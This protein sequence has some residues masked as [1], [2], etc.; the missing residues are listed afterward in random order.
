M[1]RAGRR[2]RRLLLGSLLVSSLLVAAEPEDRDSP[3]DASAVSN[4]NAATPIRTWTLNLEDPQEPSRWRRGPEEINP[5][6]LRWSI[7]RGDLGSGQIGPMLLFE[8]TSGLGPSSSSRLVRPFGS[9][10]QPDPRSS[11]A[12]EWVWNVEDTRLSDAVSIGLASDG[13]T[14]ATQPLWSLAFSHSRYTFAWRV[15]FDPEDRWKRHRLTLRQPIWGSLAQGVERVTGLVVSFQDPVRQRLRLASVRVEEWPPDS[16]PNDPLLK[17]HRPQLD[18][19][20]FREQAL[21]SLIGARAGALEDLDGDGLPELLAIQYRDYAHLYRNDGVR[22]L[23]RDITAPATLALASIGTGAMFFDPDLDGDLDLVSTAEFDAPRLFLNSGDLRFTPVPNLSLEPPSFWYGCAADDADL[24]G[25][26]DLAC[27]TALDEPGVAVI[28]NRGADGWSAS[29]PEAIRQRPSIARTGFAVAWADLCSA[30]PGQRTPPALAF[31]HAG[32]LAGPVTTTAKAE[33][34]VRQPLGFA[35]EGFVFEDL[36]RDGTLDLA[37]LRE[38]K[39][40]VGSALLFYRG[41]GAGEL[42]RD[43]LWSSGAAARSAEVLLAEDFDND[44]DLDLYLCQNRANS[45]LLL[46][47]GKGAYRDVASDSGLS[48]SGDCDA[49]IAGDIDGDGRVDIVVLAYGR[50]PELL[51]NQLPTQNWIG[52]VVA[53][54][55]GGEPIGARVDMLDPASGDTLATRWT[56]RGRG[57]GSTGPWELRFGLGA[58]EHVD[59]RVRF[60]N[61][62]ERILHGVDAGATH[63]VV[64]PGTGRIGPLRATL[65]ERKAETSRWARRQLVQHSEAALILPTVAVLLGLVGYSRGRS[66][67]IGLALIALGFVGAFTVGSM[68]GRGF[69]GSLPMLWLSGSTVGLALKPLRNLTL[70]AVRQFSR[71]RRTVVSIEQV[72]SLTTD[73]RHSG[74][75]SRALI[76]IQSRLQNL[77]VEGQLHGM[78]LEELRTLAI[79]FRKSAL[80]RLTQL[81]ELASVRFAELG[82]IEALRRKSARCA[83]LLERL[84]R[85]AAV[86]SEALAGIR[87]DLLPLLESLRDEIEELLEIL[88]RHCAIDLTAA[89]TRYVALRADRDATEHFSLSLSVDAS[90]QGA[91]AV[92]AETDLTTVLT[93]LVENARDAGKHDASFVRIK[94][95]A[96]RR[97][98]SLAV[99]DDGPGVPP[100]DAERVFQYGF[101]THGAGR[102]HGLPRSRE[103][104]A[105]YGGRLSLV[106]PQPPRGAAFAITLR[107]L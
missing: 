10:F 102:G 47:E 58:R 61:G 31:G 49:A 76:A 22:G 96:D 70:R 60:P 6:E 34:L 14:P 36:D 4:V 89:V 27:T 84:A 8:A 87:R 15:L 16:L 33:E 25:D 28:E 65:A 2:F 71:G 73:F 42:V 85:T 43:P 105:H 12:I 98:V 1:S 80:A 53:Q 5:G 20:P 88:D 78:F 32:W 57:F 91:L 11:L 51:Y 29:I 90:A 9:E 48:H 79:A 44:G 69:A 107:R 64:D 13:A 86:E 37:L 99:V 55:E 41:D 30:E 95:S 3:K 19:P 17:P 35:V 24:D 81:L 67:W 46:D 68:P 66:R 54:L 59:L 63:V 72:M 83:E 40:D 100:A 94:I 18:L 97:M 45:L 74:S 106:D 7:Q 21:S 23:E 93:S 77:F 62:H 103:L 101:S 104:L 50:A 52:V 82:E 26:P 56:R 75:E 39:D 92:I 38:H